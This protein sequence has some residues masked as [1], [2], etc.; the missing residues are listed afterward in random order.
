MTMTDDFAYEGSTQRP[1]NTWAASFPMIIW[2]SQNPTPS[3]QNYNGWRIE[4]GKYDD[5]DQE[6]SALGW[7]SVTILHG[8]RRVQHW[9][10][11]ESGEFFVVAADYLAGRANDVPSAETRKGI[12]KGYNPG[13]DDN[14]KL[15]GSKIECAVF[16]RP[17]VDMGVLTP[18]L[19]TASRKFTVNTVLNPQAKSRS[20]SGLG[21][22]LGDHKRALAAQDELRKAMAEK[23]GLAAPRPSPFYSLAM[24]AVPGGVEPMGQDANSALGMSIVSGHPATPDRD[25]LF[26]RSLLNKNYAEVKALIEQM[27]PFALQWSVDRSIELDGA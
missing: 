2:A 17:W 8:T 20:F 4:R 1:R 12:A 9:D 18:L 25:Y 23:K 3:G 10:L 15:I 16:Y 21:I 13:K 5:L 19:L 7:P 14:N 27:M 24:S 22:A 26:E 6:L 11:R